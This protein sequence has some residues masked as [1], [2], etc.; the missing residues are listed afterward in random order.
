MTQNLFLTSAAERK[1]WYT[2]YNQCRRPQSMLC[3]ADDDRSATDNKQCYVI[4]CTDFRERL[5]DCWANFFTDEEFLRD[6]LPALICKG[7]IVWDHQA[8]FSTYH[9]TSMRFGKEDLLANKTYDYVSRVG[10][11]AAKEA[12][13]RLLKAA[14]LEE[15]AWNGDGRLVIIIKQGTG[16]NDDLYAKIGIDF[17]SEMLPPVVDFHDGYANANAAAY[18]HK[19]RAS[20]H[21]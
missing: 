11:E 10:E 9:T 16:V 1:L 6:L 2:A 17:T 21:Q 12:L 8:K 14:D 5:V 7:K 19:K 3:D 18:E 15:V 20:R 4:R 13:I